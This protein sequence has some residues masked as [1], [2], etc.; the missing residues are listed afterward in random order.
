[1]GDEIVG[2]DTAWTPSMGDPMYLMV[3]S[4]MI[5]SSTEKGI[6]SFMMYQG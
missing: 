5:G 3:R 4:A 1:M 2:C 6:R